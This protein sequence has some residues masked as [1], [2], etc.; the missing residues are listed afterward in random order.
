MA[1]GT[2][3]RFKWVWEHEPREW[4]DWAA[5]VALY[6]GVALATE[7]VMRGAAWLTGLTP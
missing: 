7:L 2:V 1:P 3:K 5:L 6:A 4:Q